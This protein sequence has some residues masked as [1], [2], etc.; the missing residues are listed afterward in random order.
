MM[1]GPPFDLST[2]QQARLVIC[3]HAAH[4]ATEASSTARHRLDVTGLRG[5]AN[6]CCSVDV[7]T[8]QSSLLHG[9]PSSTG[10]AKLPPVAISKGSSC[11]QELAGSRIAWTKL[12]PPRRTLHQPY[13]ANVPPT[14]AELAV[15]VR[16]RA[17]DDGGQSC[18]FRSGKHPR[19]RAVRIKTI[20]A[21]CPGG[22][23]STTKKP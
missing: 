5:R 7:M 10:R 13:T 11:V 9:Q 6:R 20:S 17:D 16:D 15:T 3:P 21:T 22:R 12:Q 19:E 18:S 23:T 8:P 2:G 14:P 4:A 1:P